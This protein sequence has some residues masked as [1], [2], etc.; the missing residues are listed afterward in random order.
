MTGVDLGGM[1]DREY[2][3]GVSQG[4]IIIRIYCLENNLFLIRRKKRIVSD[5]DDA[6]AQDW[7]NI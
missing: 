3:G 7:R 6:K 5:L 4:K 1:G 2:L